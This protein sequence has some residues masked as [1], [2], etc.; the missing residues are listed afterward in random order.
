M[1][2]K[3]QTASL[4]FLEVCR[5]LKYWNLMKYEHLDYVLSAEVFAKTVVE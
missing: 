1:K 5:Q 4:R 2:T 3:K